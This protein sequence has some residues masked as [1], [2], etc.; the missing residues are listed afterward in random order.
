MR[1]GLFESQKVDVRKW[2]RA[3]LVSPS[4]AKMTLILSEETDGRGAV[5]ASRE[6]LSNS[7]ARK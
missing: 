7:Y 2:G 1:V 5:G 3:I 4:V 6:G